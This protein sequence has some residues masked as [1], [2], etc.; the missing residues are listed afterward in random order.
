L[1]E[2]CRFNFIFKGNREEQR[3]NCNFGRGSGMWRDEECGG[4]KFDGKKQRV[5]ERTRTT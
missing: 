3:V 1:K 2:N 5:N 4:F